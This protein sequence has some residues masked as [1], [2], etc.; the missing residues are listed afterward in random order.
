MTLEEFKK[1]EHF[2]NDEKFH[3]SFL[4]DCGFTYEKIKD[5]YG[6]Y[7]NIN[8]D[9]ML[10]KLTDYYINL[11]VSIK[12]NVFFEVQLFD[13]E[14]DF[15]VEFFHVDL[16]L[17]NK[18][19]DTTYRLI[20]PYYC[21][22]YDA[23]KEYFNIVENDMYEFY[24]S[25]DK[26]YKNT[27]FYKTIFKYFKKDIDKHIDSNSSKSNILSCISYIYSDKID[28]M[29]YSFINEITDVIEKQ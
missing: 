17:K 27:T 23:L 1:I 10:S 9:N 25:L 11:Y 2:L 29:P 26:D 21:L 28:K 20:D 19:Y 12:R 4:T 7:Y 18:K 16:F 3:E 5:E 6:V 24:L 13:N 8:V 15:D 22:S 14:I